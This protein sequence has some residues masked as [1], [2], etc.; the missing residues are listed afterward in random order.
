MKIIS[1]I[2]GLLSA[3]GAYEAFK[4]SHIHFSTVESCPTIS[5]IPACYVVLIAYVLMSLA[6]A[7]VLSQK[8]P[9]LKKHAPILFWL[10]FTPTFLLALTGIIGEI[11]GFV[12]CPE[13][14]NHFPKCFISF[15]FVVV[16]GGLWIWRNFLK[17][18]E[19]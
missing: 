3:L 8:T 12:E 14:A 10:G 13:T 11:F 2:G 6:W 5:F 9:F 19:K 4:I 15:G 16:I 17:R 1:I 18:S 7:G